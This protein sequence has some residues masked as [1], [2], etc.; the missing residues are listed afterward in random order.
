M[1]LILPTLLTL[2]IL[3][4]LSAQ[5]PQTIPLL[6]PDTTRGL[7]VMTA[8]SLRASVKDF[9]TTALL[10]KD[11]SDLC[12]VANGINR[13]GI[14][15]RTAP[16]AQNAQDIDLYIFLKKGTY[17]YYAAQH[18]LNLIAEGDSRGMFN[19]KP[20][21]TPPALVCLL[22]SDISRFKFGE[23]SL[24]LVWDAEDAGIVSQNIAVFC[25]GTGLATRPRAGMDQKKLR[26]LLKLS[27]SQHLMLNNPVS[28]RKK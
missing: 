18:A 4:N 23:D 12:W 5:S 22:V 21:D 26:D 1:K 27:A 9:D 7:P 28:Y 16:S 6:P 10:T 15:K 2:F 24:K 14:G 19:R 20:D 3:N 11:L 13:P 17:L 25:A 8:L